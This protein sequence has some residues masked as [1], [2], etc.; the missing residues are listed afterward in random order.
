LCSKYKVIVN[1]GDGQKDFEMIETV[2]A[3]EVY[4]KIEMDFESDMMDFNQKILF[5]D[6]DG[7]VKVWTESEVMGKGVMMRSM[8]AIMEWLGGAFSTQEAKNMEA[9][10]K[11]INDNTTNYYPA[12]LVEEVEVT[13]PEQ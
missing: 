4:E 12:P 3:V 5:S 10:K 1:P 6:D 2:V 8:F 13:S 7:K 9:L 11:L